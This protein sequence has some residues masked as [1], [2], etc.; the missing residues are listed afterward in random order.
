[1]DLA[2]FQIERTAAYH[3]HALPGCYESGDPKHEPNSSQHSPPTT[4]VAES[5]KNSREDASQYTKDSKTTGEDHTRS[6]TVANGPSDEVGM[7][8][9]TQRPLDRMY[10]RTEC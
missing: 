10:H 3:T 1:M 2:W 7:S 9:V 4:G 6:V 5:N 8:L